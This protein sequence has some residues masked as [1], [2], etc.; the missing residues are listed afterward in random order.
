MFR[1]ANNSDVSRLC[2]MVNGAYRGDSGKRGWTTEAHWLEGQRM[3]EDWLKHLLTQVDT[4]I[5]ISVDDSDA[6]LGCVLLQRKN[7]EVAHLGMLTVD[8]EKQIGGVGSGL[9]KFAESYAKSSWSL[10]RI[11]MNVISIRKE[12]IDWYLRRN[13]QITGEKRPFPTDERFG[14]P[15][16]D[17]L[18]FDV[19]VKNI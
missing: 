6:L 1:E 8:V 15:L 12:L 11:E 7:A 19:L 18:E 2:A 4:K 14:I 5:F 10:K 16:I 17:N 3:D 9:L 13:Y